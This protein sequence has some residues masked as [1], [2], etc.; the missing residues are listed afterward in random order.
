[1][2]SLLF[3]INISF[4]FINFIF[5]VFYVC[6]MHL[7]YSF[8]FNQQCEIYIFYFNNTYITIT[9]TCFDT[10]N[11]PQGVP[12]LSVMWLQRD[13]NLE[14]HE[15]YTN[16]SKHVVMIVIELML[17]LSIYCAFLVEIKTKYLYIHKLCDKVYL[18]KYFVCILQIKCFFTK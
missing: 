2:P 12:K 3:Q 10:L 15:Y 14:R 4:I 11:N 17:I 1:M 7:V 5:Y 8:Y 13:T 18:Q 6:T 9:P 16:I